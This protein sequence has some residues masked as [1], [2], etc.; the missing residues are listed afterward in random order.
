[1]AAGM[2]HGLR[3]PLAAISGAVQYLKGEIDPDHAVVHYNL[4]LVYYHGKRYNLAIKHFD[5]AIEL[6]YRVDPEYLKNL[7][8]HRK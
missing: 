5:R 3:S 2:A 4:A 1:M 6:G 7:E 8:P